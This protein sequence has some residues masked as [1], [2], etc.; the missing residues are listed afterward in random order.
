MRIIEL[1]EEQLMH[2]LKVSNTAFEK[3]GIDYA[4]Y[5]A[6]HWWKC[7]IGFKPENVERLTD[8]SFIVYNGNAINI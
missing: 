5:V 8:K 4:I 6:R 3:R 7:V 1:T 2:L